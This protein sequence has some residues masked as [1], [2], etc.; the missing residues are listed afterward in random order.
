[1]PLE[2]EQRPWG[3]FDVLLDS[4]EC[5]VKRITVN[6]QQQLSYQYHEKREEYWTIVKGQALITLDDKKIPLTEGEQI[7]IPLKAKHRVQN[8]N[9]TPLIIIEIQRGTYFGEDDI[10]RLED[11]YNRV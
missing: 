3:S 8:Q 9:D 4:N 10:I 6:P 5:K 11:D 1:M 2:S 7:H